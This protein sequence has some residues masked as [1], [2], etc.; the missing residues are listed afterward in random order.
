M[1]FKLEIRA[2]FLALVALTLAAPA[3][4]A[5]A[6]PGKAT[7]ACLDSADSNGTDP[8]RCVGAIEAACMHGGPDPSES[9]C[10][11]REFAFWQAQLDKAW[12]EAKPLLA[13]YPE[14]VEAQGLWLKYRDKSCAIADKVDP[15][16][17][18]GGSAACRM[19]ETAARAIAVR[20]IVDSLSEH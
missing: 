7:L 19:R 6:D 20:A 11:A 5:S 2:L 9:A 14:Q 1:S 4:A 10:A 18:P 13:T 16:T 8:G 17:M 3:H 15:G 12:K